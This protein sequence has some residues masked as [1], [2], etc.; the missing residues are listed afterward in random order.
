MDE[1]VLFTHRNNGV[2]VEGMYKRH[3]WPNGRPYWVLVAW[4]IGFDRPGR[5]AYLGQWHRVHGN[6]KKDIGVLKL[7]RDTP[8]T[9]CHSPQ[10]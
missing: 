8:P 10:C 3:E 7:L 2:L 1:I 4:R 5:E 9:I 6:Q